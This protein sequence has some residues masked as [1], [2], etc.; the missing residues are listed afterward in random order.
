LHLVCENWALW[1]TSRCSEFCV[2]STSKSGK[3][4]RLLERDASLVVG[5][6]DAFA[7][8]FRERLGAVL[9]LSPPRLFLPVIVTNAKIYT[10]RYKPSEVSLETGAFQEAPKEIEKEPWVRFFKA[11]T[12]GGRPELGFRSVFVVNATSLR[13]FLD[14]LELAP[15]QPQDKV[16]VLVGRGSRA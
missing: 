9:K 11:F 7:Q 13:E 10:A 16:R 8:D 15:A 12:S 2:V 14:A 1:P 3:D 6:T 4:Q 5:A